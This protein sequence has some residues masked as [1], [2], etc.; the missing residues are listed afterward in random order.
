ML[1]S[2][3]FFS[4]KLLYYLVILIH[5]SLFCLSMNINRKIDVG[6]NNG[7]CLY[8]PTTL[9]MTCQCC[10]LATGR[11]GMIFSL[12]LFKRSFLFID[13]VKFFLIHVIVQFHIVLMVVH[14]FLA[15]VQHQCVFAQVTLVVNLFSEANIDIS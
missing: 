12:V 9:V 14:V 6:L 5:V 1:N 4:V 13:F 8:D 10:G 3:F 11:F 7:V 15:L 2:L